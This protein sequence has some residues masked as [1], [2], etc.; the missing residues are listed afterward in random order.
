MFFWR[1]ERD[2]MK[3]LELTMTA[4]GP[5]QGET[6]VDFRKFY[7]QGLFLICGDTGAGKTTIFDAI[8]YALYDET[9]GMNR[10]VDMLRSDYADITVPTKVTLLF[11][12]KKKEYTVERTISFRKGEKR[13]QKIEASLFLPEKEVVTGKTN[14]TKAINALLGVDYQQF[15]QLS[16]I[17]QGE[18]LDL[19]FAKSDERGEVFRKI[20]N[21]D[22]YKQMSDILKERANKIREDER[23]LRERELQF[24]EGV[25]LRED[26]PYYEEMTEYLKKKSEYEI[27]EALDCLK[28]IIELD[29]VKEELLGGE[30]TFHE[31][32]KQKVLVKLQE[33]KAYKENLE[34]LEV[35][36]EE[37]KVLLQKKP[38]IELLKERL[39]RLELIRVKLIPIERELEGFT[40]QERQMQER[41]DKNLK[42]LI[43]YKEVYQKDKERLVLCKA[44]GDKR[45]EQQRELTDLEKMLPKYERANLLKNGLIEGKQYRKQLTAR[46]ED[47]DKALLKYSEHL[48][49]KKNFLLS[50]KDID[51]SIVICETNQRREEEHLAFVQENKKRV[52]ELKLSLQKIEDIRLSYKDKLSRWN[53]GAKRYQ[54]YRSRFFA[55]QAGILAE[56][57]E[58]G[59]EC[60]VCG[61]VHHPKK[62]VLEEGGLS[63]EKL[64]ELEAEEERYHREFEV[65]KEALSNAQNCHK[66]LYKQLT[67]IEEL[68]RCEEIED[69]AAV[70]EN[71]E[72]QVKKFLDTYVLQVEQLR[73]QKSEREKA[74][75]EIRVLEE[76]KEKVEQ[77]KADLLKEEGKVELKLVSLQTEYDT[78]TGE[79]HYKNVDVIEETRKHLKKEL[80]DYNEQLELLE[81]NYDTSYKKYIN[82]S[83]LQKEY[84]EQLPIIKNSV[85]EREE[86]FEKA[87]I[88]HGFTS[89]D[90]YKELSK[91]V[92]LYEE[93][94]VK[95]DK[96][97]K[98]IQSNKII[99]KT[100][101]K[102]M[103]KCDIIE[104]EAYNSKMEQY[105]QEISRIRNDKKS[106]T[107]EITN[108]SEI[109]KNLYKLEKEK[110][111]SALYR[112]S[113]KELSDTANGNL[114][115]RSKVTFERYVQTAYFKMIV[116]EANKRLEIMSEGRFELLIREESSN[117][118]QQSGL[119][120][121][122][123]DYNTGKARTVKSLS[124]GEAFKAAL[125]LALGLS[126]VIQSFAGGIEI[127]TMF[128]DEGFGALD[129]ESLEQAI[130]ILSTLTKG[131]R[132][133]GIISHVSELRER[134]EEQ[135]VIKKGID[136][137]YIL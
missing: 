120:L 90:D 71:Q 67:E 30:E 23:K 106:I 49:M 54:E 10:K 80:K 72:I 64:K 66:S 53:E 134:I 100:L 84:E 93:W 33:V 97:E 31:Q 8:T 41:L 76:K 61:S 99:Y 74:E 46:A 88:N 18:F 3:P 25:S 129:S 40:I 87:L 60:P 124:G 11:S 137:S 45:E 122:V 118:L 15:K 48:L 119:D 95:I 89:K 116:A 9:S 29:K 32:E 62:A 105:N 5:Y 115:G 12:H 125:S 82:A 132:L 112:M 127:D 130:S 78:L 135:I 24:L 59:K 73:M 36:E 57:L 123:Y 96:Y 133:V 111:A 56:D 68:K 17:A 34:K 75:T 13:T 1:W 109:Y 113:L 63:E 103:G 107:Y 92:E 4:F 43:H 102:Q 50:T 79:L 52:E 126:D 121:N 47:M 104:E 70:L 39:K 38:E 14:V 98:K 20:F 26:S 114:S 35:L 81:K 27:G 131:N 110:S 85:Q 94:K 51:T 136:G 22:F 19:L 91:Y 55:N 69:I 2:K 16:M 21:T 7:K 77:E 58:E 28:K 6:K 44:E 108:N 83:T 128:I 65:Q 117:K 42:D 101:Y 86:I 37:Q